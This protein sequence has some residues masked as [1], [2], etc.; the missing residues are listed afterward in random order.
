MSPAIQSPTLIK[1]RPGSEKH[2]V[3]STRFTVDEIDR[4]LDSSQLK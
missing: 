4:M 1:Y 3:L 2:S